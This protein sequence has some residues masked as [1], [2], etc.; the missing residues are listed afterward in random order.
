MFSMNKF[1]RVFICGLIVSL[2]SCGLIKIGGSLQG[3]TSYYTKTVKA[4][5][6]LITHDIREDMFC[7]ATVNDSIKVVL[8][9]GKEVQTCIL[10]YEKA[11]V[12]IWQPKCHSKFCPSLD[13]LEGKCKQA[14]MEL[15]VVAE[16]FDGP[17]MSKKY[18]IERPIIGI[19]TKYYRSNLTSKYTSRF[20]ADLINHK[21]TISDNR[22][23][24]YFERGKLIQTARAFEDITLKEE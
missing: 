10:H 13:I 12:Y 18:T 7:S 19:D 24:L 4:Y 9:N 8:G 6:T 22:K 5:P 16:Y 15:F 1:K 3:L 17:L 23:M 21:D 2:S 14:G 20:L 11:L